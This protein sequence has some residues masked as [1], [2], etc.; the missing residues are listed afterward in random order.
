[1]RT[2]IIGAAF[3]PQ[4]PNRY[5]ASGSSQLPSARV[6]GPC[7]PRSSEY[8]AVGTG[9]PE[10]C[11]HGH[12]GLGFTH[13]GLWSRGKVGDG[14]CDGARLDNRITPA[15]CHRL[16]IKRVARLPRFLAQPGR[17]AANEVVIGLRDVH[18]MHMRHTAEVTGLERPDQ[19]LTPKFLI[20]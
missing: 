15:I 9:R 1:M 11:N 17:C 2:S 14:P 19:A 10:S 3:S 7:P 20:R 8:S 12:V 16:I 18:D 6:V 5:R 13:D 4:F